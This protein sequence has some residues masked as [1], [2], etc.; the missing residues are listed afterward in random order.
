MSMPEETVRS[1]YVQSASVPWAPLYPGVEIKTL[2][3]DAVQTCHVMLLRYAPGAVL[4]RHRHQAVEHLFVLEG[5]VEDEWGACT[6][7]NYALRPPGCVHTPGS[8]GGALVL[9]IAYGTT[10]LLESAESGC[11]LP[12]EE[13]PLTRAELEHTLATLTA[14][15][16]TLSYSSTKAA[17]ERLRSLQQR[18]RAL[19]LQLAAVAS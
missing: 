10:E 3:Q 4:P 13:R 16:R 17:A 7:G 8:T 15:M 12:G 5:S 6:A 9:A 19:R 18:R 1:L 2:H 11:P 14:E